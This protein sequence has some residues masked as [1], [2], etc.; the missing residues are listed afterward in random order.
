[1]QYLS[2]HGCERKYLNVMDF[3]NTELPRL[4]TPWGGIALDLSQAPI[5][6]QM[7]AVMQRLKGSPVKTLDLTLN[8][9]ND[10][11]AGIVA[12][13]AKTNRQIKRIVLCRNQI[14]NTGAGALAAAM[15]MNPDLHVDLQDNRIGAIGAQMF[16]AACV[17]TNKRIIDL[18]RNQLGDQGAMNVAHQLYLNAG[19]IQSLDLTYNNIGELGDQELAT[20][21]PRRIKIYHQ[22]ERVR[23]IEKY[24]G[25]VIL[26]AVGTCGIAL[27]VLKILDC[28]GFKVERPAEG[29]RYH[30]FMDEDKRK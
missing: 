28:L 13:A 20:K 22:L 5:A 27:V 25:T 26:C 15:A 16:S 11:D 6:G 9:L 14:G 21:V 23:L 12:E 8:R 30:K 24:P 1:M 4:G 7:G 10:Q 3:L 29:C 2:F 17:D 18:S 19:S